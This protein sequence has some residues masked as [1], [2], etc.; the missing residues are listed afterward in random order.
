[1]PYKNEGLC[2]ERDLI[3]WL[4]ENT[5][6]NEMKI[7]M[8]DRELTLENIENIES[9]ALKRIFKKEFS[10]LQDDYVLHNKSTCACVPFAGH[11]Y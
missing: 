11:W 3:I 5:M 6:T 7:K 9:P 1:M 10:N 8:L 4:G 2:P